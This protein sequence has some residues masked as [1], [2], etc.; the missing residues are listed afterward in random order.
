[1]LLTVSA[2]S[3]VPI[4][5][6][7]IFGYG[8]RMEL[9][10]LGKSTPSNRT[11]LLKL[12]G[13]MLAGNRDHGVDPEFVTD[14][15]CQIREVISQT[16][17]RLV[18]VI[19]GGNIMRGASVAANGTSRVAGDHMG[20]LATVIN[21]IALKDAFT[22]NG[23]DVRLQS[24]LPVNSVAEPYIQPRAVRHLEKGR[25]VIVAGGTGNPFCTTD[26]AAVSTGLE[27]GVSVVLKATKVDGVYDKDPK[28]HSDAVKYHH[29]THNQALL[30]PNIQV[31]DDAALALAAENGL[32]IVVFDLLGE[33]NLLAAVSG[34]PV[35]TT[36][37]TD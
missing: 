21:G 29:V 27:L 15:A 1:V 31:M 12:S 3:S 34:E 36:I 13:E 7:N 25:V 5:K 8:S 16:G 9:T 24:R 10:Q 14:L 20:M 18:I 30:D 26:T 11:V 22:Q 37:Y 33:G 35:G 19:G 32:R 17:I 6:F 23:L 28:K 2:F 4:G